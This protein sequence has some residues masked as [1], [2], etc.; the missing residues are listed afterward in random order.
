MG[1]RG[2]ATHPSY[3]KKLTKNKHL[4][5]RSLAQPKLEKKAKQQLLSQQSLSQQNGMKWNF[6]RFY[7][8]LFGMKETLMTSNKPDDGPTW[9]LSSYHHSDVLTNFSTSISLSTWTLMYPLFQKLQL[10]AFLPLGFPTTAYSPSRRK[11]GLLNTICVK[12]HL[13]A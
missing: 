10:L 5:K 13:T 4:I 7:F 2:T 9:S 1:R 8:L 12:F 6:L 3:W 11:L